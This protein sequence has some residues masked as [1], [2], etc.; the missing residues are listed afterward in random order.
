M[1]ALLAGVLAVFGSGTVAALLALF[2][3]RLMPESLR[4]DLKAHG[5]M[6]V[7]VTAGLFVVTTALVVTTAW[8]QL[9]SGDREV[10]RES[11][12]LIDLYWYSFTLPAEQK[13][14]LQTLERGY[15]H[16]VLTDEQTS[17][18]QSHQLDP[19]T[20]RLVDRMRMLLDSLKPQDAGQTARYEQ[21]LDRL[22]AL[23]DARRGRVVLAAAEV[24]TVL[25]LALVVSG[26]LVVLLP[27]GM[28]SPRPAT[29]A[30]MVFTLAAMT[31]FVVY[32]VIQLN[33]PFDGAVRASLQPFHEA[34]TAFGELDAIW[35]R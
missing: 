22:N 24:P 31:A 16:Q 8:S 21:A 35:P 25:W 23:T 17:M 11:S 19:Y 32:T 26:L 10:A 33:H 18:V 1:D 5:G 6:V 4:A 7:G 30:I 28:G 20:W 13:T 3:R 34:Q 2:L 14:Q 9:G 27:V 15:V 29:L 12:A